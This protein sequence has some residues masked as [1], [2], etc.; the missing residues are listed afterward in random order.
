MFQAFI[1][2]WLGG[3]WVFYN[4]SQTPPLEWSLAS[5]LLLVLLWRSFPNWLA[6]LLLGFIIGI[7]WGNLDKNFTLNWAIWPDEA[8]NQPIWL[9]GRVVEL[10][11]V[12][13]TLHNKTKV[14]LKVRVLA[15][16]PY[17]NRPESSWRHF[18]APL[19]IYLNGY[20]LPDIPQNN[21]VWRWQ[22]KLK[23][24]HASLNPGGFNYETHLFAHRISATGYIR[25]PST[26][27][28]ISSGTLS[29][30]A[31]FAQHFNSAWPDTDFSGLWVALLFGDKS[32]I[33]DE[34]WSVL[35]AT[36]TTHLMAISGLHLGLMAT[37]GFG[38]FSLIWQGFIRVWPRSQRWAK[39]DFAS[40]GALLVAWGY[41]TLSGFAVPTQRAWW[42][43]I[44]VVWFLWARRKLQPW[45]ILAVAAGWV[46]LWEPRS[47]LMPGF[48][49][50]F[51]AVAII[52]A[53]WIGLRAYRVKPWVMFVLIQ[54]ALS[55]GLLPL[56]GWY[57]QS[58]PLYGILANL[59]AVPWVSFIALPLLLLTA[60]IGIICPVCLPKLSLVNDW[61]WQGLWGILAEIANWSNA[62]YP[63]SATD[64]VLALWVVVGLGGV[65]QFYLR[66]NRQAV[67]RA[68]WLFGFGIYLLG[69]GGLA[70]EQ[71][72]PLAR[73]QAR[74]SVLDVGQGLSVLVQTAQHHLLFDTGAK[75]SK[76]LDGASMA[77]L[78]V[79]RQYKIT[80][81]D[82]LVVSHSD[83]DHAGGLERLV[84]SVPIKQAWSGQANKLNIMLNRPILQAC[85][86]GQ[87]W[88]WDGVQFE[89]LAPNPAWQLPPNKR[90]NAHSCVLKI[91]AGD[92]R[93]L[94]MGDLPSV[95][96]KRLLAQ[97]SLDVRADWLIAGHHG[98]R[99]STSEAWLS[100]VQP[101]QVVFSSG[102]LNRFGFPHPNVLARVDQMG[103]QTWNTACDGMIEFEL[104]QTDSQVVTWRQQ[105]HRWYFTEC[106][107]TR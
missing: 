89:F 9:E 5:I 77:I 58:I 19:Q 88:Q 26:S 65:W 69:W 107:N 97:P 54:I 20:D 27:Q 44:L 37:F 52:F 53:V 66:F 73:Q 33:T 28:L 51:V 84:Q 55:L 94:I 38:L 106:D 1:I 76:R 98:S 95:F 49:L 42:M 64:L 59:V 47:V 91:T 7:N 56:V 35:Q 57:Y 75:W 67:N 14:K 12:N 36:G 23:P 34:Q 83:L 100:A 105:Q 45:A 30:R 78:P 79:L 96:E 32:F 80:Q 103:A 40:V 16:H 71:P 48:W 25:Q 104:N 11:R 6:G 85:Q 72:T 2:G 10:P 68:V 29:W 8:I 43:L 15:W 21:Q 93:V 61:V 62:L 13:Q 24:N 4:L 81:L 3:L 17:Q 92:E 63:I 82:G 102:F 86:Q 70:W 41:L 101:T 90:D 99:H 50:S 46:T 39:R 60:L 18:S 31:A 22:V 74:I 87:A